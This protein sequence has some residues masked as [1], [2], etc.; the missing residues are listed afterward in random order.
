M[1]FTDLGLQEVA[2]LSQLRLTLRLQALDEVGHLLVLVLSHS[3]LLPQVVPSLLGSLLLLAKVVELDEQVLKAGLSV[4]VLQL[5]IRDA[6]VCQVAVTLVHLVRLAE[7]VC[8]GCLLARDLGQQVVNHPILVLETSVHIM[9]D[10]LELAI[11]NG[12]ECST[13]FLSLE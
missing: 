10:C 12:S 9:L 1:V 11:L 8:S 4:V 5:Q 2:H 13:W 7:P 3:Q 6:L